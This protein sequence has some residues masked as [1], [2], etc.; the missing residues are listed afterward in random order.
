MRVR[1]HVHIQAIFPSSDH[2]TRKCSGGQKEIRD[3]ERLYEDGHIKPC[4]DADGNGAV[5]I[6]GAG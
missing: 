5:E 2:N 3:Q 1:N 4:T 6:G